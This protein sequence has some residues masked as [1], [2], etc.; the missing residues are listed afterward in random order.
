MGRF[1]I[2]VQKF[3]TK[4]R[5]DFDKVRRRVFLEIGRR[6]IFKTPVDKGGAR[7][8][9]QMTTD[10]PATTNVDRKGA[11]ALTEL[12]SKVI[13]AGRLDVMF[14]TNL[15]PYIRKLE[16]G[17]YPNP[18]K[19]S[20]LS[21]DFGSGKTIG[22]FSTQAPEGMVRVTLAEFAGIVKEL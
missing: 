3:N 9:W 19:S 7:G 1:A 6:V 22:G 17:G 5:N 14:L 21:P 16:F 10:G 8:G 12:T 4:A 11:E 20:A 15:M 2:D 18:P 13:A